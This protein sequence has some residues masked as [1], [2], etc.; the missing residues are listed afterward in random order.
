MI[1]ESIADLLA[2]VRSVPVL[3][4]STGLFL[5]GKGA[6]PTLQG[7][8]MPGA[9]VVFTQDQVDE[10]PY[11]P[12]GRGP[13]RVPAQE[14]ILSTHS[15]FIY[16]QN[17]NETDLLAVQL[18]VIEAVILAVKANGLPSPKSRHGWRYI[19]QRYVLLPDRLIYEQ[20]YTLNWVL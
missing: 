10:D 8:S 14:V 17:T 1:A 6:D 11:T 5:A 16:L 19:G 12:S 15:V 13:G 20:R 2:R 3:A 18:P 4:T 7:I 9:N